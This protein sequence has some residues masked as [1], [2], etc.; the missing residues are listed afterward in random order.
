MPATR[1]EIMEKHGLDPWSK[2]IDVAA[3]C[4]AI[5]L[6]EQVDRFGGDLAKGL[7]AYNAGGG[8]VNAAVR[9]RGEDWLAAL[10][11]ETRN[12]VPRILE[13]AGITGEQLERYRAYSQRYAG[14]ST[15]AD[16]DE[17]ELARRRRTLVTAGM[18]EKEAN[19]KTPG[20][21]LGFMFVATLISAVLGNVAKEGGEVEP[22]KD[23]A[24]SGNRFQVAEADPAQTLSPNPAPAQTAP[25]HSPGGMVRH[26]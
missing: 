9:S 1:Q 5:Y 22:P 12:Y 17:A 15:S 10:P 25:N 6:R 8:R 2:D 3:R 21:L 26:A 11:G 20:E 24:Q 14:G 4:G 13:R 18:N 19:S 16:E 7:A 23:P